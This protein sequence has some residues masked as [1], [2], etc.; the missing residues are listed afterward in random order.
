MTD[1]GSTYEGNTVKVKILDATT[2]AEVGTI[3]ARNSKSV[4]VDE[5]TGQ[6]YVADA[7]AD[8]QKIFVYDPP[9]ARPLRSFGGKGTPTASSPACG[10]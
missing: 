8:Q 9:A 5:A 4:A 2:G 7:G 1:V 3:P 10:A 6:V